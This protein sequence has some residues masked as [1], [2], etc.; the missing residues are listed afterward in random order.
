LRSEEEPL[1][2]ATLLP[3]TACSGPADSDDR[4]ELSVMA[5]QGSHRHPP[6]RPG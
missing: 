1:E 6:H 2:L 5:D 4:D 3:A